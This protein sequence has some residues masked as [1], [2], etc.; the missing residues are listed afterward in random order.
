MMNKNFTRRKSRLFFINPQYK[1]YAIYFLYGF[2]FTNI[3]IMY[4]LHVDLNEKLTSFR[5]K[6]IKN[7]TVDEKLKK[8]NWTDK[9]LILFWTSFFSHPFDLSPLDS[10]PELNCLLTNNL[11]LVNYSSAIVFHPSD[12]SMDDVPVYRHPH[13]RYVF[14]LL[15][16]PQNTVLTHIPPDFF[17]WTMTYRRDSDIFAPYGYFIKTVTDKKVTPTSFVN[18]SEILGNN[19]KLVVWFASN[20]VTWS[21]RE[22][23]VEI[24]QNHIS[25]DVYG[26]C[27]NYTCPK[28]A[29]N[30]DQIINEKYKFYLAFEN[31]VCVD[32]ISEKYYNR[33][34]LNAVPIVLKRKTGENIL[35]KD[36]FIA[37]DDFSHPFY[38]AE[39]LKMLAKNDQRYLK[40]FHWRNEGYTLIHNYR[41]HYENFCQLCQKLWNDS[42]PIKVY[43]D[44]S[45]W[46]EN[47]MCENN[48]AERYIIELKNLIHFT[49]TN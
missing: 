25:V 22:K 41:G 38:L 8:W 42:E 6:G 5:P 7:R 20:C 39:H 18:N 44:I 46:W 45:F 12:T 21:K 37:V 2:L 31:S 16:S 19:K 13:Q 36:S 28:D 35:P 33:A 10:C 3:F 40:Y 26:D 30:C 24:L 34:Y 27:G 23:Y 1:Q 49:K 48:F 4:S 29:G 47:N 43:K 32:Y 14:Y 15:E 9:R 11:S 17:N